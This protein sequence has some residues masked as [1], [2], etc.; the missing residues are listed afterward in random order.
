MQFPE[1]F[2]NSLHRGSQVIELPPI[3]IELPLDTT[4]VHK[5]V[6]LELAEQHYTVM[7]YGN[8][9][10]RSLMIYVTA[11]EAHVDITK[12]GW[13][14]LEVEEGGKVAEILAPVFPE[15]GV[16]FL[17]RRSRRPTHIGALTCAGGWY[18]LFSFHLY[19]GA[20]GSKD[21]P[22]ELGKSIKVAAL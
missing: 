17:C 3:R 2:Q 4:I 14:R 22:G 1:V 13:G 19:R 5:T 12:A 6:L 10:V 18:F 15:K 9:V 7:F 16:S 20:L 21:L 11:T 8:K